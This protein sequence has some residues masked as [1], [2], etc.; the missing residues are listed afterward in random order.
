M[1]VQSM[2]DIHPLDQGELKIREG[3]TKGKTW[4]T[5]SRVSIIQL[6]VAEL[7]YQSHP[8]DMSRAVLQI[9][10]P[11][12]LISDNLKIIFFYFFNTCEQNIS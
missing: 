11:F 5:E 12:F 9:N 10:H 7:Q 1:C 8:M 6:K 2:G 3:A 4:K